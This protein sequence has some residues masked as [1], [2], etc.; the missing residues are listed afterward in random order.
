MLM[1]RSSSS[2]SAIIVIVFG[3]NFISPVEISLHLADCKK[4]QDLP[5]WPLANKKATFMSRLSF[6]NRLRSKYCPPANAASRQISFIQK[7]SALGPTLQK[8]AVFA[9][10]CI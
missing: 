2:Q 3:T 6:A 7:F 1:I 5:T 8:M 9:M 10:L 4:R